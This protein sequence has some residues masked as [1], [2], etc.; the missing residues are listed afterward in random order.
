MARSIGVMSVQNPPEL[1]HYVYNNDDDD[2]DDDDD[3]KK[4]NTHLKK[5]RVARPW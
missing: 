3:M 5:T 4:D 2:D 1:K